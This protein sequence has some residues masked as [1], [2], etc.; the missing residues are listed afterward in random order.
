M[1]AGRVLL[2]TASLL[3]LLVAC[4]GEPERDQAA[5]IER[6]EDQWPQIAMVNEIEYV[7]RYFPV[8]GC[9][10]LLEAGGDTVAATAKHVLIYFK[11]D[12]MTTISFDSSLVRWVMHPKDNPADSVVAGRLINEDPGRRI[13]YSPSKSDWLLF[14]IER[15]SPAIEP[16]R[17]RDRPLEKGERVTI[18]G[19]RYTDLDCSQVIYRGNVVSWGNGEVIIST[20]KL[21][22][23][24]IPGLSGA[25]VIDSAGRVI[26]LMSQKAGKNERLAGIEYARDILQPAGGG[27]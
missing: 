6:P 14:E 13:A 12:S 25:P 24:T 17:F 20:E 27:Q 19:W 10:F 18:V 2:V 22:D 5:W 4:Q 11:S 8:A 26:G 1:A 21:S 15:C 7:D 9:A 23:N 3:V 16:L